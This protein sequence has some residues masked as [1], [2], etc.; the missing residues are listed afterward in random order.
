MEVSLR[1][2]W[3]IASLYS[4]DDKG[5]FLG[6][7]MYNNWVVEYFSPNIYLQ[8]ITRQACRDNN[9]LLS[10]NLFK[11]AI[12]VLKIL[13][14]RTV[15]L[16]HSYECVSL[17]SCLL[18]WKTRTLVP[19]PSD[20]IDFEPSEEQK[21]EALSRRL[22]AYEVLGGF[23]VKL[24]ESLAQQGRFLKPLAV[25]QP[26]RTPVYALTEVSLYDLVSAFEE[27]LA[28][29]ESRGVLVIPDEEVPFEK[30]YEEVTSYILQNKGGL[31][32]YKILTLHRGVSWLVV[33]FLVVLELISAESITFERE[34]KDFILAPL[35]QAA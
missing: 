21:H 6:I 24:K 16:A 26:P 4:S 25:A 28:R 29:L 32:L 10:L 14:E 30:A 15:S 33:S 19:S 23:V 34:G 5:D 13:R 17:L 9:F 27:V 3:L 8:K 22:R 31:S 2:T 35:P 1:S 11:L 20:D 7:F 12:K 18:E